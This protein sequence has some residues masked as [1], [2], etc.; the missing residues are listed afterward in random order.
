MSRRVSLIYF[1]SA[2]GVQLVFASS[3][4]VLFAHFYV[5]AVNKYFMA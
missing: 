4:F 5:S 1:S 2:V 3:T